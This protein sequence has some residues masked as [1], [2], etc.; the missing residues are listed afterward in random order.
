MAIR[1]SLVVN[2]AGLETELPGSDALLLGSAELQ[3]ASFNWNTLAGQSRLVSV[4]LATSTNGPAGLTS[5]TLSGVFLAEN[6]SGTNGQFTGVHRP[7]GRVFSRVKATTWQAWIEGAKGSRTRIALL[8]HS[9]GTHNALST[10]S[11]PDRLAQYLNNSGGDVANILNFS[12]NGLQSSTALSDTALFGGG[13][14]PIQALIASRPDIVILDLGVND[15]LTQQILTPSTA[16]TTAAAKANIASV[17]STI[18]AALPS[19]AVY[20]VRLKAHDA[21]HATP[22]TLLNRHVAFPVFWT[23]RTTGQLANCWTDEIEGDALEAGRRTAYANYEDYCDYAVSLPGLAGVLNVDIFKAARLGGMSPDRMHLNELGMSFVAAS[24][25]QQLPVGSYATF[26]K[27]WMPWSAPDALF[28]DTLESSSGKWIRKAASI[29]QPY[30][31]IGQESS[32]ASLLDIDSW[33]RAYRGTVIFNR[34]TVPLSGEVSVLIRG[35]KPHITVQASIDIG[36]WLPN[37][38]LNANGDGAVTVPVRALGV[39]TKLIRYKIGEDIFGPLSITVTEDGGSPDLDTGWQNMT[40]LNS[41]AATN[42]DN[43][44]QYRRIGKVVYLRGVVG[45]VFANNNTQFWEIP[46]ELRPISS[47]YLPAAG[48]AFLVGHARVYCS[49]PTVQNLLAIDLSTASGN[50]FVA[51]TGLSW[52]IG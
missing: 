1:K 3:G 5:G 43:V 42:S 27:S 39:G 46:T 2:N 34:T 9:L 24:I 19:S 18:K 29:F 30:N 20:L 40:L 33:M 31:F 11:W 38:T 35:A 4:D 50:V 52:P 25:A 44:P 26:G 14:T 21:T 41:W 51:L 32:K 36:P 47:L 16:I 28:G 10:C 6:A 23:L 48:S 22:A 37:I 7:T 15:V 17:V 45:N 49:A 12:I 8:G 13:K